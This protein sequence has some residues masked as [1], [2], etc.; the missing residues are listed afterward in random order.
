MTYKTGGYSCQKVLLI[1]LVKIVALCL[2][3]NDMN[4]SSF[5]NRNLNY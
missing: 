1:N 2:E 5:L 3:M 4:T